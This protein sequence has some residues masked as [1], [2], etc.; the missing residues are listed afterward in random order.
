[1]EKPIGFTAKNKSTGSQSLRTHINK[2]KAAPISSRKSLGDAHFDQIIEEI[3]MKNLKRFFQHEGK[4]TYKL[5]QLHC[6][7]CHLL[8]LFMRIATFFSSEQ[9]DWHQR[10][11]G[12]D[13][14]ASDYTEIYMNRPASDYTEIQS[15]RTSRDLSFIFSCDN[16]S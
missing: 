10:P 11:A 1:M 7:S 13:H 9:A 16:E 6:V 15:T 14:C 8:H 12:Y 4:F 2:E 3:Y 5:L